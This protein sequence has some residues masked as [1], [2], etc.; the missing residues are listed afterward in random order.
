MKIF[1]HLAGFLF[2]PLAVRWVVS[3]PQAQPQTLQISL[4]TRMAWLKT[5]SY[6]F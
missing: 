1:S 4:P 2:C 5:I 6:S 3:C